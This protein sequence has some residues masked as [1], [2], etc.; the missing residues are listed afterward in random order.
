MQILPAIDIKDGKAVRLYK[1]NFNKQTIYNESPFLQAQSFYDAGIRNLH[2]VDLDGALNGKTAHATLIKE[3]KNA[4]S[5]MVIEIGGGIRSMEQVND[6]VLSGLDRLIIGS[7]ALTDPD[8]LQ[9]AVCKYK[10]KIAVGIDANHKK[11][12]TSGW[13]DVGDLDYLE[14]AGRMVEMGIKTIIYTDISKD[15]TLLGPTFSHYR[16]LVERFPHTNIIA[17]GGIAKPDDLLA[18]EKIGVYGAIVG[19]AFY[20]GAISLSELA[21]AASADTAKIRLRKGGEKNVG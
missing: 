5:D 15:G 21:A 2:V 9:E 18:L 14:F 11:V 4:F 1:G 12:A 7:A 8:F 3:I 19:K 10:D 17:S 6:Y 16:E 20:E 13:L